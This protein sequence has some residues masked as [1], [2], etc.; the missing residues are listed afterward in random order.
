MNLRT[1]TDCPPGYYYFESEDGAEFSVVDFSTTM[2]SDTWAPPS[3][4]FFGW[5]AVKI[6]EGEVTGDPIMA[7][8]WSELEKLIK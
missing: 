8:T 7:S 6:K 5:G 1:R 3:G 2:K 4:L